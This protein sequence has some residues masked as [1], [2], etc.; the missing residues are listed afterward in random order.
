MATSFLGD[1]AGSGNRAPGLDA[2]GGPITRVWPS[3]REA[4]RV[5]TWRAGETVA[6][7]DPLNRKVNA[8]RC[9]NFGILL[10]PTVTALVE[11]AAVNLPEG[12]RTSWFPG[13]SGRLGTTVVRGP[14]GCVRST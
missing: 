7:V 9:E 10:A 4:L 12:R 1:P 3:R 5:T 14:R 13:S 6:S 2:V 11:S 8:P